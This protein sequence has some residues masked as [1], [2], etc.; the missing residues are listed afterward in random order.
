MGLNENVSHWLIDLMLSHQGVGLSDR[1]RRIRRR[2]LGGSVALGGLCGFQKLTPGP[3]L[4]L[5][6]STPTLACGS[7]HSC[8]SPMRVAML[9]VM[10]ILDH[11]KK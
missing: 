5:S 7:G 9:L 1:I 11:A 4:C 8:S 10:V 6:V 3:D 2:G